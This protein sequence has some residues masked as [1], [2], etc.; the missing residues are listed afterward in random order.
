MSPAR[1]LGSFVGSGLGAGPVY[2][3]LGDAGVLGFHYPPPPTSKRSLAGSQWGGQ[4][5]LWVAASSYRGPVLIRGR[6]LDGPHAVGFG[7]A[8]VPVAEMQLLAAGASSP[9]EPPGWREWPS[10]TRLRTGGCY[11]YQVDGISFSRLIVFRAVPS[12]PAG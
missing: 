4:K 7:G 9:G 6:Q 2:P 12:F 5:V 10:F 1:S 8:R 3:V 11:A